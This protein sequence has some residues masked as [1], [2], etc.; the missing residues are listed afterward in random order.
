MSKPTD[1]KPISPST[2]LFNFYT[3]SQYFTCPKSSQDQIPYNWRMSL[4]PQTHWKYLNQLILSCLPCLALLFLWK[5]KK[6]TGLGFSLPPASA[7]W[8]KPG[9]SPVAP[10]GMQYLHLIALSFP[11]VDAPTLPYHSQQVHSQNSCYKLR[12]SFFFPF[13]YTFMFLLTLH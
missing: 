10:H 2:P 13:Q 9:V 11:P 6:G 7:S 4:Y 3:P 12:M 5:P 1:P 8:P